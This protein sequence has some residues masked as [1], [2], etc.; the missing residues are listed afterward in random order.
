LPNAARRISSRCKRHLA[1]RSGI[2]PTKILL[3]A[4]GSG[5]SCPAVE[6][7]VELAF[8]TGSE[9]HVVYVL[10]TLPELPY[11]HAAAR[12]RNEAVL[13]QRRIW[14]FRF[15]DE[16]VGRVEELG[17]RVAA[18]HYREGKPEEEI[19]RLGEE[20]G[21]GLIVSGGRRRP[22]FERIFGVGFS[23][24]LSRRADCPVLVVSARERRGSTVPR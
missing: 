9:L 2:F 10:S 12:E 18:T 16:Q 8:G 6:A 22:W 23:E 19:V 11:P 3:A 5:E 21:A 17:G 15:L 4:D 24:R 1:G 14:A 7:A 13:E 20:L